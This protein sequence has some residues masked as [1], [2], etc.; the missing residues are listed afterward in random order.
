MLSQEMYSRQLW[1]LV[2]C[3]RSPSLHVAVQRVSN[4]CRAKNLMQGL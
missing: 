2:L 4:L 3:Y 1:A